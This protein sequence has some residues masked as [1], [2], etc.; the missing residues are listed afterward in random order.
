MASS[1]PRLGSPGRIGSRRT[2]HATCS[3]LHHR[4]TP[5]LQDID[6]DIDMYM[7]QV[8][9]SL[10]LSLQILVHFRLNLAYVWTDSDLIVTQD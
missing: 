4:R 5:Q 9:L 1:A 2:A 7:Y 8:Q 6:I 3:V 10:S